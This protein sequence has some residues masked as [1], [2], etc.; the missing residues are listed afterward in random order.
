[1]KNKRILLVDDSQLVLDSIA[2]T[3]GEEF[4]ALSFALS[5]EDGVELMKTRSFDLVI[6]DLEMGGINGIEV[7]KH[8]RQIQPDAGVIILTGAGDMTTAIQ[9]LRLGADDYLLKPCDPEELIL[10]MNSCLEKRELLKKV[11]IY[12]DILPVCSYCKTIRDDSGTSF[13]QG[14][15]MSLEEYLDKKSGVRISHGCCPACYEREMK[16]LR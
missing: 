3:L 10:R 9:A 12:E 14:K 15:W 16:K 4:H 7:L 11:R 6:T 2:V 1:M 13:G 8:A 5:G